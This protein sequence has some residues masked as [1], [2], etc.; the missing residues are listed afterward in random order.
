MRTRTLSSMVLLL[1]LTF[2]VFPQ[3][4]NSSIVPSSTQAANPVVT[5]QVE[6]LNYT[7]FDIIYYGA[8]SWAN[9]SL[10]TVTVYNVSA[11]DLLNCQAGDLNVSKFEVRNST[12]DVL[13][14]DNLQ[15]NGSH[16]VALNYSLLTIS[17]MSHTDHYD[18][19]VRCFFQR[20][21]TT[22]I[23]NVTTD[24]S[25]TFHYEHKLF[26]A[27]PTFTYIADT[28]YTID[29]YVDYIKSSIWGKLNETSSNYI[30]ILNT[31]DNWISHQVAISFLNNLTYNSIEDRWEVDEL[32]ITGLVPQ[33]E[34]RIQVAAIYSIKD[35]LHQTKPASPRSEIFVFLGPYLDIADLVI[36]YEGRD[37]QRLNISVASVWDSYHG[38]LENSNMTL[39]NFSFWH[40]GGTGIVLNATFEWNATGEYWYYWNFNISKYIDEGILDIGETY[41]IT[42]HFNVTATHLRDA[43]KAVSAFSRSFI[44]DVDPPELK[45]HVIN[46]GGND[47]PTDE[48]EAVV[49]AE[50]SDDAKVTTVILS[51]YNGSHW[52]NVT[53]HSAKSVTTNY[54]ATIPVFPERFEVFYKFYVNDS[55]N[56][57]FVSQEYSYIVADTPPLIA[58]IV[59]LPETPTDQETVTVNVTVTDGTSV[60]N[61]TLYYSIDGINYIAL[62]MSHVSGNLYQVIIPAYPGALPYFQFAHVLFRVES[63][64][65]YGNIRVSATYAYI[66]QGTLPG[67]DPLTG[68]LLLITV[69]LAVLV[70]VVL[71]KIY[72]RY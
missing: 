22:H 53:M 20:N 47:P 50:V 24:P 28:S 15:F 33:T 25:T 67:I 23:W 4:F 54:T 16:W 18:L 12:H 42:A 37:V 51:Y 32:N 46:E 8:P 21:I 56:Q 72:E 40:V 57:W 19:Y 35:P 68:L 63:A 64:D 29:I 61:V 41:N 17:N 34:Y 3:L 9:S 60:Y 13:F 55:Q 30:Q 14:W 1:I 71:I 6:H 36:R 26:V 58:Y 39:T 44:I 49:T 62:P 27:Q 48:D 10:L 52:I 7:D 69:A 11:P 66:V 43:I 59:Y 2:A 65:V 70:I 45:K 5:P 31:T 38:Y